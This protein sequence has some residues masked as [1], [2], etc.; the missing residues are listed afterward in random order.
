MQEMTVQKNL[1]RYLLLLFL[2]VE[3]AMILTAH[4]ALAQTKAWTKLRLGTDPTSPPQESLRPDGTME[5]FDIDL[6]A[7]VC[8]RMKVDC[9]WVRQNFDGFIPALNEGKFDVYFVGLLITEKRKQVIDFAVPFSVVRQGFLVQS[10]G[11][12]GQVPTSDAVVSL[13][14]PTAEQCGL[15][16][17]AGTFRG[18]SLGTDAGTARV[19]M[20]KQ[21]LQEAELHLYPDLP[22]AL[23]D[24]VGGHLD[25][26]MAPRGFIT[27]SLNGPN[28]ASLKRIG[29][30]FNGG[31]LGVGVSVALRKSDPDLKVMLDTAIKSALADGTVRKLALK[32]YKVDITPPT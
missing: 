4:A 22:K 12:L 26:I 10:Q 1:S 19:D 30:W 32:W 11:P 2:S 17:L 27:D 15:G 23:A 28:G 29:T 13:P 24:L 16:D 7:D 20:V 9:E 21:C 18:K 31:P 3:L 14:G 25:V 5:G 8:A 6:A